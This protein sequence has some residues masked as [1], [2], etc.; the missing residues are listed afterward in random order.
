MAAIDGRGIDEEDKQAFI[1]LQTRLQ[2]DANALRKVE[3]QARTAEV[4]RKR[5]ELVLQE[6]SQM[7]ES[8]NTYKTVG[9]TFVLMS[10]DDMQHHLKESIEKSEET[11]KGSKGSKMYLEKAVKETEDNIRELLRSSPALASQIAGLN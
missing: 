10:K 5:A 11:V 8:T 2:S 6:L 1:E 4:E 3:Q 9:R 7:P